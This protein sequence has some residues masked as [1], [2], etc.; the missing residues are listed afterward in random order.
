MKKTITTSIFVI[1]LIT[2]TILK[3]LDYKLISDVGFFLALIA[4]FIIYLPDFSKNLKRI[5]LIM[6]TP[7][8]FMIVL[9]VVVFFSTNNTLIIFFEVCFFVSL[10]A[11]ILY[12][13]ITRKSFLD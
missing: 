12:A 5:L 6:L 4:I 2:L 8:V 9:L 7:I 10:F 1:I 3:S 13:F 11:A